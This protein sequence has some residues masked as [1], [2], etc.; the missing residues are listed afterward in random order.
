M[1]LHRWFRDVIFLRFLG[2]QLTPSRTRRLVTRQI[3]NFCEQWTN[4]GPWLHSILRKWPGRNRISSCLLHLIPKYFIYGI[5][6]LYIYQHL[7]LKL[8]ISYMEHLGMYSAHMHSVCVHILVYSIFVCKYVDMCVCKT[9]EI[10]I[11]ILLYILRNKTSLVACTQETIISSPMIT[12][13]R[14]LWVLLYLEVKYFEIW[15]DVSFH[16]Y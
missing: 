6:L 8:K 13:M 3:F 4:Q 15:A 11:S 1:G 14:L 5:Y 12:W 10:S 2:T 9:Q 16:C 7:P